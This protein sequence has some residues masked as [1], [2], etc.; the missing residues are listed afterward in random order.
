MLSPEQME[1]FDANGYM[2]LRNRLPEPML[3]RLR[4]A[5]DR[6]IAAGLT[7]YASG[8]HPEDFAVTIDADETASVLRINGL[9]GKGGGESLELLG[10]PHVM[11]A[12]E[13]LCG[14]NAVTVY[15]SLL[16]KGS[17]PDSRVLWHQDA[18]HSRS[19]RVITLGVYLDDS[20]IDGGALRVLPGTQRVRQNICA[21]TGGNAPCPPGTLD[22]EANAGDIVIHDAM[23]VHSSPAVERG[24][25]RRT[26]YF[27]FRSGEQV[28]DEGPWNAAWVRTR[29]SLMPAAIARYTAA[30]PDLPGYE[31]RTDPVFQ[32]ESMRNGAADPA[33]ATG[34]RF[35]IPPG[36]YCTA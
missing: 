5:A 30:Y 27:E 17:G 15:E 26:V 21:L 4:D 13:S 35:T 34:M 9:H 28:A 31:P 6:W 22:I 10:S 33:V 11:G 23:V 36:N 12:A 29:L 32:T 3:R 25:T 18:V 14:R 20:R 7:T 1:F 16:I 2:V 24:N 8:R 19:R